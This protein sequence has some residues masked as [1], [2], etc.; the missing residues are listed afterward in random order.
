[1]PDFMGKD[2]FVWFQGC[3]EDRHDP[4]YLGRCKIRI[5]GWHT[6]D[7]SDM[8][9]ESL[10]WAYPVQPIT[11]A[12]QTGV[13]I[14]PT[15]PVEGTWVIGFFRDGQEGQDPMFFGTL[16]GIP[17]V[18]AD[19]NQGFFDPRGSYPEVHPDLKQKPDA[20]K[21]RLNF[22]IDDPTDNIPYPPSNLEFSKT[23]LTANTGNE[24]ILSNRLGVTGTPIFY[25]KL[26]EEMNRSTYPRKEDLNQPT[27]PKLARG[28]Y[29]Q[30]PTD[31]ATSIVSKKARLRNSL[32]Q[33]GFTTA[34]EKTGFDT[35]GG[36][37]VPIEFRDEWF[38]PDP[39]QVY[40]AKYPYNHVHQSESG[41]VI[42]V[43]DTPGFE[44]LHR[45]HRTGT[46][47][48][49]GSL[50][51]KI[52]KVVNENFHVGLNSDYSAILGNKYENIAGK[53]DVVSS[54]GYYHECKSGI[55]NFRSSQGFV[56]DRG[57]AGVISLTDGGVVIDAG[58]G[59]ITLRGSTFNK[60]FLDGSQTDQTRGNYTQKTGGS[61]TLETGSISMSSRGSAQIGSGGDVTILA[62][63]ALEETITNFS[64]PPSL[65]ARST[66]ATFGDIKFN[67]ALFG[68]GSFK[69]D[70]GPLGALSSISAT[71]TGSIELKSLFGL[72]GAIS[73]GATGVEISYLGG[74]SSISVGPSGV[75]I[76]GLSIS[77]G[78][79]TTLTTSVEGVLTSVKGTG[80]T[81][82][83]G[84]LVKLN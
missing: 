35:T 25:T 65:T 53:L 16:G 38:Q 19:S 51:Q 30:L 26:E 18:P 8:P 58:G 72:G 50:G 68:L 37:P 9:T 73:I 3:V 23:K 78:G 14:S 57:A 28:V 84:A 55:F 77:I 6:E 80:I 59:P 33:K 83:E 43:D 81:T 52:T 61:H 40:R 66:T 76:S 54:K 48:E 2:G 63:G 36:I 22:N 46:F 20:P 21:D 42:E 12:A 34:E 27:T 60:Q 4:L 56:F 5:L 47:E 44:R 71:P 24:K 29:G 69:V 49:I 64:I 32:G 17:E 75:S 10:P 31:L 41:H 11:S 1:M 79:S 74:L 13:G 15:G 67:T 39:Q 70:I 7:K 82:V 62:A 45:Y